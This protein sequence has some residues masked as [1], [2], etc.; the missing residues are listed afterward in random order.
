[1]SNNKKE[2][3]SSNLEAM[4]LKIVGTYDHTEEFKE[5]ERTDNRWMAMLSYI[6][7]PI[8]FIAERHSG[9]VKFHS[10]Q[11]MNLMV[12]SILIYLFIWV[13]DEGF[14]FDFIVNFLNSV[15][16][17]I[18]VCLVGFGVV[19]TL[20]DKAKELPIVSKL[21]LIDLISSIIGK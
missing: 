2:D 17:I 13:F 5:R 20:Q 3:I 16:T 1:M 12:W 8:P 10:N 15:T 11:G 21:N 18:L 9:Y 7:P 19:T 14:T 6:I 4:F